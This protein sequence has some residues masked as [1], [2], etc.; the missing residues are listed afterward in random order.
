[1]N[2]G[3][4]NCG[5]VHPKVMEALEAA[6]RGYVPSYG[7]DPWMAQVRRQI[8]EIFE[9]PE[10]EVC[11]VINGTTANALALACHIQTWDTVFCTPMAHIAV[12]ECNAPEFFSGGAKLTHVGDTPKMTPEALR[13]AMA[14]YGTGDVHMA[15]VGAL[16]LTNVTECGTVYSP[17][18][19]AALSLV[20]REYGAVVHLDGARF[21]NALVALGC[22]PA[23]MTWKA[24]VDVVSF[25]GTKNGCMGVEA[26]A[27][28]DPA[29]AREFELRRKRA[30]HLLSKHR[31][32]S[33]QMEAYVADGLWLD[34]AGRANAAMAE[35]AAG[36]RD[37][38]EISFLYPAEA[39][40]AF[41]TMPR[42]MHQRLQAAGAVYG[43]EAESANEITARLVC[44]WS[45]DEDMISDFLQ[46]ARA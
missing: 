38:P 33:A 22:T 31:Y 34:L 24:G 1:M 3:S 19:I 20:A 17:S 30:G 37:V 26:V 32:L 4:D 7:A 28:F 40:M 45:C 2:F 41:V 36:L 44:D 11:L 25:G 23:D 10:A 42:A 13:E 9:A 27:L 39:N 29:K 35:L 43:V 8:R 15:Q 46:A 18:E 14:P 6:N 21:A 12:D 16:S 5:P